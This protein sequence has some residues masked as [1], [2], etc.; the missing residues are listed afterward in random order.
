MT[1][2]IKWE[3]MEDL[4][5]IRDL[6]GR[7]FVGRVSS[8]LVEG[9]P[10][11]DLYETDDAF[12]AEID[13]P[14]MDAESLD[15]SVVEAELTLTLERKKDQERKYLYQERQA[16]KIWRKIRL[17]TAVDTEQIQAKLENGVLVLTMP[18]RPEAREVKINVAAG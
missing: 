2:S 5:A 15:I 13:A 16:G 6:V 3:P 11:M 1:S 7:S 14:G 8:R 4:R 12:V 18:K 17:P 10:L 9:R